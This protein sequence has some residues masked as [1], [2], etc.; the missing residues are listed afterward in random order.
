VRQ[1]KHI[2]IAG[3]YGMGNTGDEAILAAILDLLILG[4]GGLFFMPHL[5]M[6]VEYNPRALRCGGIQH[7]F[8]G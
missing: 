6:L 2:L 4:G 3:S 8:G 7:V 1:N 5:A